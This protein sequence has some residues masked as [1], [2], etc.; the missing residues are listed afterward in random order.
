MAIVNE[1]K[2]CPSCDTGLPLPDMERCPRCKALL[3][4]PENKFFSTPDY[5][6][7]QLSD[8]LTDTAKEHAGNPAELTEKS[9]DVYFHYYA[10]LKVMPKEDL[11]AAIRDARSIMQNLLVSNADIHSIK[12]AVHLGKDIGKLSSALEEYL[13]EGGQ[14]LNTDHIKVDLPKPEDPDQTLEEPK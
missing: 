11:L 13:K 5:L 6:T 12:M 2:V 9:S 10:W 8:H 4:S 3:R 1:V 7:M 14:I